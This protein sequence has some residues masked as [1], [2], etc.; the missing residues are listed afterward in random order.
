MAYNQTRPFIG[1]FV[2]TLKRFFFGVVAVILFLTLLFVANLV[3]VKIRMHQLQ[4]A[5]HVRILAAGR[6]AIANRILYRNDKDKEW[7][8]LR[9]DEVLLR[10]P[11]PIALPEAI[12]E[13]RPREVIISDEMIFIDLNLPFCRI[14][15]LGF[16]LGAAQYGTFRYIDGLW[17]WNGN[18]QTEIVG[19]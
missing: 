17:F 7:S 14:D 3:H 13:L 11:M 4:R 6:E 5:D 12:R 18:K 16:K 2:I 1:S 8:T 19:K 15:L 10:P 9:Q